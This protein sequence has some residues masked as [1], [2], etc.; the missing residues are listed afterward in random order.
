MECDTADIVQM[1]FV[2]KRET[3]LKSPNM[4][5]FGYQKGLDELLEK[6]MNVKAVVT[7]GHVQIASIMSKYFM[8]TNGTVNLP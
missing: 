6:S 3:G 5:A 2:D 4:E 1:V 8:E 7:D